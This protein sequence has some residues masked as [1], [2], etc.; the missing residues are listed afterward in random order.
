MRNKVTIRGV[1]IEAWDA[2]RQM[3]SDEQRLMG[4]IVSEAILDYRDRFYVEEDTIE[5]DE[6]N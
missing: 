4:A 5:F 1:D 2:L 6:A 3:R